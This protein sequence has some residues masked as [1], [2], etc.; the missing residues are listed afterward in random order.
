MPASC[1]VGHSG[2]FLLELFHELNRQTP[3][4]F[5]KNILDTQKGWHTVHGE[6]PYVRTNW[7]IDMVLIIVSHSHLCFDASTKPSTSDARWILSNSMELKYL[8]WQHMSLGL[9]GRICISSSQQDNHWNISCLVTDLFLL[10]ETSHF[11][12]KHDCERMSG[13]QSSLYGWQKNH[14]GPKK[15]LRM[16]RNVWSRCPLFSVSGWTCLLFTTFLHS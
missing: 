5:Q 16:S 6:K 12:S 1:K 15:I 11:P 14:S 2:G 4:C 3:L 7:P 9:N 13:L 10:V 8:G